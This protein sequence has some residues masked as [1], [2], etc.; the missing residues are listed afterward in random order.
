MKAAFEI[1]TDGRA[2]LQAALKR[3]QE[4]YD[5]MSS[6]VGSQ[7]LMVKLRCERQVWRAKSR[8]ILLKILSSTAAISRS[9]EIAF[10]CS[11]NTSARRV[12]ICTIDLRKAGHTHR[13]IGR[14]EVTNAQT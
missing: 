9:T 4:E 8:L 6:F 1:V 2:S 3:R 10:R 13:D 7:H 11:P 14:V 5:E 12:S